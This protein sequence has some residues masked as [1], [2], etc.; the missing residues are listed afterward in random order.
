MYR[1]LATLA[2]SVFF[3][4]SGAHATIIGGGVTSG[5]GEFVHLSI[6][7]TASDPDNTV[8]IDNFNDNNLYGFDEDQNIV[9][10]FDIQV[11]IGT[12]PTVGQTVASHY[13]FFDPLVTQSQSGFVDFDSDIFG[14]ATST[15]NLNAS[16]FLA[17]TAITYLGN[18]LR[19]IEGGDSV[20]IDPTNPRRLWVDWSAT[21]P[22]DYVRVFT[23]R[24]PA[25]AAVHE[26][27]TLALIGFGLTALGVARRFRNES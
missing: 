24:S 5:G 3:I 10:P 11:D 26:P 17:N 20:V 12:N 8:G 23:Q 19:G 7:F 13:I 22:G 2:A 18:T 1:L 15:A 21:T 27:A 16:D 25:A 6:P 9:I 14:I 4:S